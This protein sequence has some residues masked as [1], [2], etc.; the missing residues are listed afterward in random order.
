MMDEDDRRR[1]LR[2]IRDF[3]IPET[4]RGIAVWLE[5]DKDPKTALL[6]TSTEFK[7]LLDRRGIL[8]LLGHVALVADDS[9]YTSAASQ[10][11]E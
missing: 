2:I 10:D 9:R 11:R 3:G 1:W 7:E 4:L 8:W 5:W 6:G